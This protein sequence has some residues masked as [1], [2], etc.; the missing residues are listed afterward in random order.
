MPMGNPFALRLSKRL[1]G[2]ESSANIDSSVASLSITTESAVAFTIQLGWPAP[3]S[4]A[5]A[6][7]DAALPS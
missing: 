4:C 3:R 7:G 2:N 1:R 5:M 6:S